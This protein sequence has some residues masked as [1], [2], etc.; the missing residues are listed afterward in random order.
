MMTYTTYDDDGIDDYTEYII[1][2]N[3]D[4]GKFYY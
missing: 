1:N 2:E 4:G 3:D